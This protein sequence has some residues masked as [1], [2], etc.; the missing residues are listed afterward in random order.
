MVPHRQSD[1]RNG[2]SER[3][4]DGFTVTKQKGE[5][6]ITVVCEAWTNLHGW[7]LRLTT[8]GRSL[9]ATV[10]RSADEMRALVETWR[11]VLVETGWG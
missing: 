4:V 3:L 7:E 2:P 8:N 9:I 1:F 5:R 6:S 10:V 11:A